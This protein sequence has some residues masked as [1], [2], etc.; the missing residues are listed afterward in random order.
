[1]SL[2]KFGFQGQLWG[3][4]TQESTGSQGYQQNFYL[5]PLGIIFGGDISKHISL[6]GRNRRSETLHP[7]KSLA[8]SFLL[9]DARLESRPS[10]AFQLLGGGM[11]CPLQPERLTIDAELPDSTH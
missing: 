4:W 10:A 11:I 9:Q 8:S 1:M 3:D 5:R 7:S 6:F 2:S